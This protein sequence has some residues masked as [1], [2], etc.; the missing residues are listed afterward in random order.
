[1]PSALLPGA[2][3]RGPAQ[4]TPH[5]SLSQPSPRFA[6]AAGPGRVRMSRV[7]RPTLK[8]SVPRASRAPP[9]APSWLLPP[10]CC[11]LPAGTA[12]LS[13]G[14]GLWTSKASLSSKFHL[15]LSSFFWDA[16]FQLLHSCPENTQTYTCVASIVLHAKSYHP[17]G[18]GVPH[19][20]TPF[21]LELPYFKCFR[22]SNGLSSRLWAPKG[23][24]VSVHLSRAQR[25][26]TRMDLGL[27]GL[28]LGP[29]EKISIGHF[30]P[31]IIILTGLY[32]LLIISY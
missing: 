1:M 5:T 28:N 25:P 8:E 2:R 14:G 11:P 13:W 32:I 3:A 21:G 6:L 9:R 15:P 10:S 24:H 27:S 23:Q 7:P 18:H 16:S 22:S 19:L 26:H 20:T 30:P 4:R 29:N 12:R 31:S 17:A